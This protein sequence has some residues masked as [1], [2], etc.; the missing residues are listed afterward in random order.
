MVD[1]RAG[2]PT[3]PRWQGVSHRYA[4][5]VAALGGLALLLLAPGPRAPA[6]L[7]LFGLGGVQYTVGALVYAL[8]RP[9]QAPAGSGYHEVFH[10]LVIAAAGAHFWAIAR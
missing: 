1:G 4:A 9:D 7:A 2:T 10:A 3:R 5:A 6:A 8:R